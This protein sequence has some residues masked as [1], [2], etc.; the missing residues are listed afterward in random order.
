MAYNKSQPGK[1]QFLKEFQEQ[2]AGSLY[3]AEIQAF[4]DK[5]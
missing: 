1:T 3:W 4:N 5:Q 2:L